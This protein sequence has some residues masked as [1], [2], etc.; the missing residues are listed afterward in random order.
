MQVFK[1]FFRILYKNKMTMLIYIAIFFALTTILSREGEKNNITSFSRTSL[2]I[3][4]DNQDKG[5]LGKALVDY[6]EINNTIKEVPA[7]HEALLDEMYNR[8]IQYVLIIPEDFTEKFL[9][10]EWEEVLEG[11]EVP[12]NKTSYLA[13]ME[14]E[15]YLKT[16]GMYV[17]G[18]YEAEEAVAL[19]NADMQ[20]ESSVEFLSAEDARQE[21]SAYYY[22]NYLPYIFVCIM[23]VSLG[24]VLIAFNK[25]DLDDRN[26]CSAMSFTKRN[27]QLI[28][29][30]VV[31]M[32][33]EYGVFMVMAFV[34][35]PDYMGGIHGLLS[36][37]NALV[38]MLLCLSIA[39]FAGRL[40]KN[41]GEL[42][43]VAN[44]VGLG[45]SFLGGV[46]VSLDYMSEGV[47]NV[48]K[49][50]PSY[51]YVIS[52]NAIWKLESIGDAG[53][54]FQN[55]MVVFVFAVAVFAAALL[56]N[57]LKARTA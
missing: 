5:E 33:I 47:K 53:E 14:I 18:G 46:F 16:L 7:D 52:N 19:A 30:S 4:V 32:L 21:P 44:I 42:N 17:E 1:A 37:L 28:L 35:Y 48:S 2:E 24:A 49:F 22:F 41:D 27:F 23:M 15:E 56:V 40:L 8:E 11:T 36:A 55:M 3:G 34:M 43:M 9:A 39:F 38:Y 25:K 45:C 6:L 51:W 13:E 31:L 50:I 29:G 57:R 20:K 26:R 12:G 54:V 10:G